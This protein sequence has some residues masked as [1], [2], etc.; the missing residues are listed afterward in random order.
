MESDLPY[1]KSTPISYSKDVR[2]TLIGDFVKD[3]TVGICHSKFLP[4]LE[5][6]L[7]PEIE[8]GWRHV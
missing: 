8:I 6:G 4:K 3:T 1:I 5:F 2:I 7:S